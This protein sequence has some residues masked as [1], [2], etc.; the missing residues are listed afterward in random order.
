M[1]I[2]RDVLLYAIQEIQEQAN[3]LLKTEGEGKKSKYV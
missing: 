2:E 1:K 3:L